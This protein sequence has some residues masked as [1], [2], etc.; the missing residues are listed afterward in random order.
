MKLPL[1]FATKFVFR[2]VFPGAI[3]AAAATPLARW[4]LQSCGIPLKIEY[5]YPIELIFLGWLIVISDMHI[6]MLFEGR[7]YWPNALRNLMVDCESKR[8]QKIE[9]KI[10]PYLA[11]KAPTSV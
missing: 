8:L 9:N 2:L 4:T 10:R 11:P 1:E 6:Y 3:L 7:R 5:L